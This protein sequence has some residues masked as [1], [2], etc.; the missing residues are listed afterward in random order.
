MSGSG[1][2]RPDH[3]SL[4]PW[5]LVAAPA[6]V[7]LLAEALAWV[8]LAF[9]PLGPW[10]GRP[11]VLVAVHLFTLGTLAASV[12]GYGWQLALVVTAAPPPAWWERLA[13]VSN[14][15]FFVGLSLLCLGMLR[16]PSV[17]AALGAGALAAALLLRSAAVLWVLLRA[18]GQ[19][20]ARLWLVAA[21]L[22]LLAGLVLGGLL[23]A[24][25]LGAPVLADPFVGIAWHGSLLLLGWIGG[26]VGGLSTVLLPMFAVAPTPSPRATSLAALL[27][28]A[29]LWT[30]Q[31]WLW[32][33]GA[34]LLFL[35]LASSLR[36]RVAQLSPGL[37]L[38]AVGLASL[39]LVGV[40]AGMGAGH[41]AGVAALTLCVL[42]VLRGVGLRI[43]PFLI[44]AS[45][46][47]PFGR[48]A[49]PVARLC[50]DRARWS[51]ALL[52]L[53]G[54]LV[55]TASWGWNL[56]PLWRVG[57]ALGAVGALVHAGLLF[58]AAIRAVLERNRL[59]ALPGTEAT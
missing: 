49:P 19:G 3:G 54:G 23:V 46:L 47:G 45:V 37:L 58:A 1:S 32:G 43:G 17:L 41:L 30:G 29:G 51:S 50:T 8:L 2:M 15:V 26:W 55:V 36:R 34:L 5:Q 21:E 57:A 40:L 6:A 9:E 10:Y 44:W 4:V 52:A 33:G 56:D 59:L 42:P 7:A 53:S 38:A 27:W 35:A 28:Y 39:L 22:S 20:P 48:R 13:R 18:R 16:L 25:R 31:P 12:L 24:G 14:L 11:G